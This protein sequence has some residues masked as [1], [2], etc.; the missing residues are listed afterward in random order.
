L[1]A[2]GSWG[3]DLD[4]RRVIMRSGTLCGSA[5]N[6]RNCMFSNAVAVNPAHWSDYSGPS[7][8]K[9][10]W[11]IVLMDGYFKAQRIEVFVGSDNGV[12]VKAVNAKWVV[13]GFDAADPTTFDPL[14]YDLS[15]QM[16]S[17]PNTM[18]VAEGSYSTGNGYGVGALTFQLAAEMSV[19]LRGIS[20]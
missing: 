12:Y 9:K 14:A 16:S 5:I 19:S 10:Q 11:L 1:L 20:C 15:A 6:H 18:G 2:P 13:R 8:T 4:V 7:K 17:S 3:E